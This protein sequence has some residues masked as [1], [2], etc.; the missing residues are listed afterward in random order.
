VAARKPKA[1][2]VPLVVDADP[3]LDEGQEFG[4]AAAPTKPK[5][6]RSRKKAA[7]ADRKR[8]NRS[9]EASY[10]SASL[11]AVSRWPDEP[12]VVSEPGGSW[13]SAA[14]SP[15]DGPWSGDPLPDEPDESLPSDS[16]PDEPGDA[17]AEDAPAG[18][19]PPRYEGRTP[20]Q[21]IPLSQSLAHLSA[22]SRKV[23][24]LT[25]RVTGKNAVPATKKVP[26]ISG[27]TVIVPAMRKATTAHVAVVSAPL[28]AGARTKAK[29]PVVG[30]AVIAV[31]AAM[32]IGGLATAVVPL[33]SRIGQAQTFLPAGAQIAINQ[34]SSGSTSPWDSSSGATQALGYGGGAGPGVS[35][36]GSAGAPLNGYTAGSG[37]FSA[38]PGLVFVSP[39]PLDTWPPDD[40]F[41]EVPNHPAFRMARPS[42]GYYYWA[43]GQCTWWAQY[44]RKDENLT[45]IGDARE[46]AWG[47]ADRGMRVGRLPGTN[48][49]VVFLPGAQG[50]GGLGHV[51]HVEAVYPGGWFLISEMNFYWNGGGWGRVDY[52]FAH[53]GPGV[54]FIY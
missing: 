10:P 22:D 30:I 23:T 48:A 45:Y 42:D 47:A 3:V 7:P 46:W 31:I 43:F 5:A 17:P 16:F 2:R 27:E 32:V 25:A 50:A 37:N 52:R 54:Y 35:A 9:F 26:I 13:P 36:P 39:A 53:T 11:G 4:M 14:S 6:G 40:P 51:G 20:S 21:R 8:A 29:H 12:S 33:A 28:F 24:S 18:D 19:S 41:M 38:N 34:T 15:S 44:T 49:S 1:P